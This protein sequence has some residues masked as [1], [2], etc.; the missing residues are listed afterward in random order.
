MKR[1]L[2]LDLVGEIARVAGAREVVMIGSQVVHAVTAQVPGEVLMSRRCD[3]LLDE[4]DPLESASM[5][6]AYGTGWASGLVGS[7]EIPPDPGSLL[8]YSLV[9]GSPVVV[10]EAA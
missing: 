3:L 1:E 4:S 10:A 5:R 6:L 7:L 9:D 8:W 2:L